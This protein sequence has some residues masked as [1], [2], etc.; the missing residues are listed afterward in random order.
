MLPITAA[1]AE[2][3]V[4]KVDLVSTQEVPALSTGGSGEFR[5]RISNNGSEIQYELTYDGL[6]GSP[7]Q[8]HIHF[9]QRA[10]NGGISAFLC[11]NLGNAPAGVQTQACPAQPGVIIGTITTADVIGPAGQG[12]AAGELDELIS[13]IRAG[14][15][16]VNVHT[17]AFPGGEIRSQLGSHRHDH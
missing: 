9:G 6:T 16:Y 15:A 3:K 5:A 8:A 2:D 14:A 11:T 7:T 13:A 10:V 4:F 12:I 17:A 1:Q